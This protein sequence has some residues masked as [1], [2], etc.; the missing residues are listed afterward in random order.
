MRRFS[1]ALCR[2]GTIR[3]YKVCI[4]SPFQSCSAHA[5]A[6]TARG[7][8]PNAD[9]STNPPSWRFLEM[10]CHFLSAC[11]DRRRRY[12][13]GDVE[14][15]LANLRRFDQEEE[16]PRMFARIHWQVSDYDSSLSTEHNDRLISPFSANGT[17]AFL[18]VVS[19]GKVYCDTAGSKAGVYPQQRRC[20][21]T[22]SRK[23][24]SII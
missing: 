8:Q 9:P 18:L 7:P 15:W 16:I 20:C 4:A 22:S 1:P 6:N 19:G 2:A 23:S 3:S 12:T 11:V 24:T 21:G 17:T 14:W 13:L 5:N 10:F